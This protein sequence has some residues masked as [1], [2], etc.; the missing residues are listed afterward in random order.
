[1]QSSDS[2]TQAGSLKQGQPPARSGRI[3]RLLKKGLLFFF[4]LLALGGALLLGSRFWL[5][6]AISRRHTHNSSQKII[7][8]KPGTSSAEI[9]ATLN[10][11]GILASQWPA[12]LWLRLYARNQRFKAGDY[13]FKSPITP[14]EV[15]NILVKGE[16]ATRSFTIP[17]GYNQWDIA[18]VLGGLTGLKQPPLDNPDDA[19][20]LFKNTALIADLDSE[21]SDLEGL[22]LP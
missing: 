5:N 1:M 7:T 15:I 19:Q 21:A 22:P 2:I 13:A 11:E 4:V 10:R 14:R 12:K 18:R 20:A 17:E 3:L 16:V 9:L 6:S 8:F